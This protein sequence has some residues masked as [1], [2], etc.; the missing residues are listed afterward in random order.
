MLGITQAK[1]A[2]L[3]NSHTHSHAHT[4]FYPDRAVQRNIM[5][6]LVK[7][8]HHTTGCPWTGQLKNWEVRGGTEQRKHVADFFTEISVAAAQTN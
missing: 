7:C 4:H 1:I 8:V 6:I 3:A 2:F 5:D